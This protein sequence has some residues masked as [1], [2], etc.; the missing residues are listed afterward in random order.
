MKN[1]QIKESNPPIT[2]KLNGY[3]IL[4]R[5]SRLPLNVLHTFNLRSVSIYVD[6]YVHAQCPSEIFISKNECAE[7]KIRFQS[8]IQ[9]PVKHVRSS[10]LQK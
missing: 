2:N 9:S 6:I 5:R 7:E 3:K 1:I 4:R 10:S 8:H